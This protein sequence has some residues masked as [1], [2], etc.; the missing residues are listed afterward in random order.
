MSTLPPNPWHARASELA[1]WA[2]ARFF[3]RRDRY[4]VYVPAHQDGAP[5]VKKLTA[6]FKGPVAGV[7]SRD[8]LRAHF[9]A[10]GT[11]D[12]VGAHTLAPGTSLGRCVAVDVDAHNGEDPE[13]NARYAVELYDVLAALHFRPLLARWEGSCHLY[14]LLSADVPGKTLCDFGKALVGARPIETFPKQHEVPAGGCGNWL[15]VVGRHHTRDQWARVWDG[16]AWLDGAAAVAHVLSL[17]GDPPELIP[18]LDPPPEPEA[19]RPAAIPPRRAAFGGRVPDGEDVLAAF[20]RSVT[21]DEVAGWHE[22]HGH[23]VVRRKAE[24][25]EL[26]RAG[27]R[28]GE[29]FNVRLIAGVPVTFNFS[30]GAGLPV[31][32]GL[33]PARVRCFYEL[34]AC[35]PRELCFFANEL[36]AALGVPA[37][38]A[39]HGRC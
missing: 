10:T 29:S 37:R 2:L 24:R 27:K 11:S 31:G 6:P 30:T 8:L 23:R 1:D 35:G 26:V 5:V 19:P 34:G 16:S 36:R 21:L 12:V 38:G 22:A 17:P 4:G 7:V 18:E 25:V 9:R 14:A 20:N 39:G 3:V 28:A 13:A 15:R 33:S 32:T